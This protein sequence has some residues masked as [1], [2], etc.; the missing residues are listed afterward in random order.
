MSLDYPF[1]QELRRRKHPAARWWRW[2]DTLYYVGL[3][4]AAIL[5]IP[6]VVSLLKLPFSRIEKWQT[7]SLTLFAI[8]LG[9]FLL[10]TRLKLKAWTMAARD[11]ISVNDY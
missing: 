4:P 3:L 10:G 9:V 5:A 6:A 2:G 11:G 8:F 1:Y 7:Y